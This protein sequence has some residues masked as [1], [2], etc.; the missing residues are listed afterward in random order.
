MRVQHNIAGLNSYRQFNVNN[1]KLSKNLEKLSSGYSINRAGDD[2][3]GLAVSEKMRF[4]I[5]GYEAGIKNAKDGIGAIQTAE[6]ALAEVHDMLNRMEYLSAQNDN[7]TY[8]DDD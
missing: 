4:A 6:G 1:S 2:A 8:E 7:G 5:T 3:A